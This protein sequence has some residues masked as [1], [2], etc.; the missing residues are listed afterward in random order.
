[1]YTM[2]KAV[3]A[4][5][6]LGVT[7]VNEKLGDIPAGSHSNTF[8]GNLA[9][10]AGAYE[11]LKEVHATQKKLEHDIKAKGA[12]ALKR[13]KAM[14]ESYE[15]VGDARGLGF[16]LAIELVKDKKSKEP[17]VDERR[18]I[19]NMCF[20]SGLLLLEAGQSTIRIAPPVTISEASL[21]KGLDMLEEAVRNRNSTMLAK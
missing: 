16:M 14:Q 3:G 15:I 20:D 1:M 13:L 2:A 8:G 17:A 10:I 4:G 7:I 12:M 18:D 9:V 6:P 11:Q 5:L 19:V 21:N